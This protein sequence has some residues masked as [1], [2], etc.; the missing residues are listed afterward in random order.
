M[1]PETGSHPRWLTS[2]QDTLSA[3][4]TETRTPGAAGGPGKPT[5]SNP[6]RAPRS[7]PTG[8]FYRSAMYQLLSRINAYLVRWI[9]KKY[10]RLQ[11]RKKAMA[12]WRGITERYPCMFAHW[13]WTPS[14]PR[15]W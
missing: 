5:G 4:C 13:T 10:K 12:C 6:G 11:A 8:A 1:D 2:G 7:D 14:V 3:R 9:R 15:V